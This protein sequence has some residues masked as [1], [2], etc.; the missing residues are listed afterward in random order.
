MVISGYCFRMRDIVQILP[1]TQLMD[2]LEET[3]LWTGATKGRAP[4]LLKLTREFFEKGA[5]TPTHILAVNEANELIEIACLW[6]QRIAQFP[7]LLDKIRNSISKGPTLADQEIPGSQGKHPRNLYF[8][9][10]VGGCLLGAGFDVLCVDGIARIGVHDLPP[11]DVVLRWHDDT[12]RIECKRPQTAKGVQRCLGDAAR[13]LRGKDPG[14]GIAAVDCSRFIRP[15]GTVLRGPSADA[16]LVRLERR[17]A[18]DA[19]PLVTS[20]VRP[21]ISGAIAVARVPAVIEVARGRVLLP[22]GKPATR[23]H[24]FSISSW[25]VWPAADAPLSGFLDDVRTQVNALLRTLAQPG[26]L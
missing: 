7:G 13:Q 24:I 5:R 3:L 11:S 26:Y 15:A 25:F 17:V 8:N 12:V 2:K 4:E 16:A 6:Q 22:S 21:S 14:Y 18:R 19:M 1:W 20:A 23:S 10:Y 9:Y